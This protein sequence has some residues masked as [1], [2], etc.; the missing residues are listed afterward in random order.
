M[1]KEDKI[2]LDYIRGYKEEKKAISNIINLLN[3]YEKYEK[4]GVNIPRG[5]IFQ[6]PPGT[7]KTLF[8][9]AIAGE[10][11]YKFYTAFSSEAEEATID[12]LK[13]VFKDAEDNSVKTKQPSLIYIDEIDK[14][15]YTNSRGELDS[16]AREMVRFLL[17]K[18]DE[19]KSKN[20]ILIIAS[21]NNYRKIPHALLRSG[22][23]D[24]KLLIDLPDTES[25]KEILKL[26][27]K[28]HPLFKNVNVD[29]LALKTQGMSGADLKTLINNTLLEYITNKDVIEIDDFIKI[30]QEM[31]F[32]TIGK[33]WNNDEN[34]L[35]VLAHEV[36]HALVAYELTGA[37]GTVSAIRYGNTA[38]CTDLIDD[39]GEHEPAPIEDETIEWETESISK[40]EKLKNYK[41]LIN[42][43]VVSFG[44]MVSEKIYL[45][46]NSTG[47]SADLSNISNDFDTLFDNGVFGL[48]YSAS[49]YWD[50]RPDIYYNRVYK[51]G[52]QFAKKYYKQA[53]K[54]VKKHKVLGLYLIDEIHKNNDVLSNAELMKRIREF[55]QNKELRTKY[56]H[57]SYKDLIE[58]EK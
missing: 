56:A 47:V 48:K 58:I 43:I 51:K 4:Q 57:M 49:W 18:L 27:I 40:E 52:L 12:T 37:C 11:N 42:D 25:R 44:G 8:A 45:S 29:S 7:G 22:R 16:E 1:H 17:Q 28:D 53:F 33:K 55:K 3:N 6:G 2:T 34:A 21:T 50:G 32:E 20:K 5:L 10:C 24:K 36:G 54:I 41:D 35:E 26:Y 39:G 46:L 9:K 19:T 14:I 23:F 15:A 13:K 30:I 38:G 31:N